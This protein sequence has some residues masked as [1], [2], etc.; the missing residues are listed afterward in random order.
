MVCYNEWRLSEKSVD[1][2]RLSLLMLGTLPIGHFLAAEVY[3][4]FSGFRYSCFLTVL[5]GGAV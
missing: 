3:A 5:V 4:R 1:V 2:V